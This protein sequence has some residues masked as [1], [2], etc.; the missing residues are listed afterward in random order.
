MNTQDAQTAVAGE[1][2]RRRLAA[3]AAN[4][5]GRQTDGPQ[6]RRRK[7][8]SKDIWPYIFVL[9]N[10]LIFTTFTI[11]PTINMFNISMYDSNNGRTF[12]YVG[13]QNYER[14]FTSA[15]FGAIFGRT[16]LFTLLFVGLTIVLATM[17]AVMLNKPFKGRAFFRAVLFLPSL[18][19]AVVIG[20]LWGWILDRTNGLLNIILGGLGLP[21]P[22]WLVDGKLA[23]IVIVLVGLWMH[24]GFYT[25]IMLSGLQGIDPSVYEA[26]AI[27]GASQRQQLFGITLPL[28]RPT[29]LVVL[30]LSTISG[31]QSFDFIWTLTGGGPVG[32]TTLMVQFIYESAFEPP[33]RYGLASAGGVVLFFV[34]LLFTL[35]NYFSNRKSGAV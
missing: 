1:P 3:R 32:A 21:E 19:S 26:A 27:D 11:L 18:L 33:I 10:L 30:I 8:T 24:T 2:S 25:L 23:F 6:K 28:L 9:P 7:L 5:T 16:M 15:E 34:V 31:F 12:T 29:M 17:F 35:I 22:G 14:I 4:E 13:T 20:L